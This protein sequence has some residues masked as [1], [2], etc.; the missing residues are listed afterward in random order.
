MGTHDIIIGLLYVVRSQLYTVRKTD[1]M[2]LPSHGYKY[3][4]KRTFQFMPTH[5]VSVQMQTVIV[6]VCGNEPK[7]WSAMR[8]H[9]HSLFQG[10]HSNCIFKFSVSSLS[11]RIFSQCQFTRFVTIT[12][13]SSFREKM[14]SFAANIEIS[15]TFRIKEFTT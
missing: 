15:F 12:Y 4:G 8:A 1:P 5:P 7:A 10:T 14:E 6:C 11:D 9:T 13:F 2:T 3:V